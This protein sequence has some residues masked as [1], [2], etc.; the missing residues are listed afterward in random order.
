MYFHKAQE[1]GYSCEENTRI[2]LDRVKRRARD[3][4][5]DITFDYLLMVEEHNKAFED[6]TP[7]LNKI[8]QDEF[9]KIF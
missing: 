4:E 9:L 1:D 3:G 7:P 5:S 8:N 6:S 2:C